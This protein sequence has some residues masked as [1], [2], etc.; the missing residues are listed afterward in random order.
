MILVSHRRNVSIFVSLVQHF[1]QASNT[2]AGSRISP[3]T[4]GTLL[5]QKRGS[6]GIR[7]VAGEIGISAATLSRIENGRLPDL[8]TLRKVCRWLG[9]D[10][11]GYFG[12]SPK[13]AS[14]DIAR[15]QIVFKKDR[16]VT[17]STSRALGRLIIEAYRQ[18]SEIDAS[19][20]E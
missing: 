4:L 8:D 5:Q 16:A 1:F 3:K 7:A 10:P 6:M 2:M 15:L 12:A 13:P 20:H 17:Q 14:A 11:A 19:G 9:V 18:F